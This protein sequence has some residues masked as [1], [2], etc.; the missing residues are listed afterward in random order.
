MEGQPEVQPGFAVQHQNPYAQQPQAYQPPAQYGGPQPPLIVVDNGQQAAII[1]HVA[2]NQIDQHLSSGCYSCYHCLLFLIAIGG[3]LS[4]LSGI[5]G[6]QYILQV[7]AGIASINY[8][9]NMNIALRNKDSQKASDGIFWAFV[10]TII[11]G[12]NLFALSYY[13]DSHGAPDTAIA[14]KYAI[15]P[16]IVFDLFIVIIPAFKIT[17]HLGRRDALLRGKPAVQEGI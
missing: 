2:I 4:C 1:D 3:T 16:A 8:V 17:G 15:G 9:V 7:F 6:R 5:G 11:N 14:Y 10:M 13:F 12:V